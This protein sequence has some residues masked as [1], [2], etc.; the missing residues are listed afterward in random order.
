MKLEELYKK[1]INDENLRKL[2]KSAVKEGKL[3]EFLSSNG[4]SATIAEVKKF[5]ESKK[6]DSG[7]ELDDVIGGN[8]SSDDLISKLSDNENLKAALKK[9]GGN[10]DKDGDDAKDG[11]K[12][13]LGKFL[14]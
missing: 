12:N 5:I 4:C 7:D 1:V 3:S 14:H 8:C 9:I 6:A 10:D 13:I 2:C 11:I